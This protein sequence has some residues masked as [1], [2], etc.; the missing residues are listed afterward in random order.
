MMDLPG[1]VIETVLE[2]LEPRDMVRLESLTCKALRTRLTDNGFWTRMTK[3]GLER[4]LP[5]RAYFDSHLTGRDR[6]PAQAEACDD[7]LTTAL[8]EA[9]L[10]AHLDWHLVIIEKVP[11]SHTRSTKVDLVAKGRTTVDIPDVQTR[12]GFI[13]WAR[14]FRCAECD[15]PFG[16]ARR[17]C[18]SCGI[19]LCLD[20]SERCH[21][22]RPRP[23]PEHPR[24]A[25]L[26]T[27]CPFVLCPGCHQGASDLEGEFGG[28]PGMVGELL[29]HVPTLQSP[30]CHDCAADGKLFCPW[31]S[32]GLNAVLTC[33]VC[34]FASCLDT[35]EGHAIGRMGMCELCLYSC[36]FDCMLQSRI[37][38][39]MCSDC[40]VMFCSGCSPS[41]LCPRCGKDTIG[42]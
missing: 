22:D 14:A 19:L 32:K 26:Q 12:E 34:G 35:K 8:V 15:G 42:T 10:P 7:A 27:T 2:S 11:A 16:E 40:P 30:S 4:F 39:F 20:C 3:A 24:N 28:F 33:C 37:F 13:R 18:A 38:L 29:I 25:I 41:G 6:F 1:A 31:H 23:D 5:A 21:E 36:C 17:Q 9:G